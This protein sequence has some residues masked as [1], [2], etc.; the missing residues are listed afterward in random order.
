MIAPS[1]TAWRLPSAR[2]V[3]RATAPILPF[4]VLIGCAGTTPRDPEAVRARLP[5]LAAAATADS[6]DPRANADYGLAL[7]LLGEDE[8][9]LP[10]L[11]RAVA[12]D[13]RQYDAALAMGSILLDRGE[14]DEAERAVQSAEATD[15]E[16][17]RLLQSFR[18]R[19]EHDRLRKRMHELARSEQS[20]PVDR[21]PERSIG[22]L[23][24]TTDGAPENLQGLG[25]AMTAVLTTKLTRLQELQVVERQ[26]LE[27]LLDEM[28]LAGAASPR[29]P[30]PAAFDPVG[31]VRGQQQRLALL[32]DRGAPFY[33][34]TIDG[35][36]GPATRSAI[37]AFQQSR[38]L[39]ADGVAGSRT[40]S[41][42][43]SAV[44]ERASSSSDLPEL[45]EFEVQPLPR[46]GRLLGARRILSGNIAVAE[47]ERLRV[48]SQIVDTID[49]AIVS[50]AQVE[51]PLSEFHRIP[52]ELVVRT[53]EGIGI[54]LDETTRRELLEAPPVTSSLAAFLAYGRGLTYE[55][56]GLWENAAAEYADALRLSPEFDLARQRVEMVRFGTGEFEQ[57]LRRNIAVA[58][59]AQRSRNPVAG[60]AL[61]AV[62]AETAESEM[63][64]DAGDLDRA[65]QTDGAPF[66][67]VRVSGQVPVR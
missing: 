29:E 21:I 9:A 30:D 51:R 3:L 65:V 39:A 66:G 47:E 10:V 40:Q 63:R 11:R 55:D 50:D 5:E 62:G 18:A 12:A 64:D 23:D 45:V 28:R 58:A 26:K 6:L 33:T 38:G 19:I 2:S 61:G 43:E 49:G 60:R 59:A 35:V 67:T 56:Q 48:H 16:S 53:A 46:A 15:S 8:A 24:F 27:V 31:T 34:G 13:P 32:R 37:R 57:S 20:I 52:G 4:L 42:L 14:L 54:P 7:H 36:P 41:A 22:V 25:K 1:G 44:A 17:A